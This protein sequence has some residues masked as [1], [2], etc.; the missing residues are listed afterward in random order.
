[1]A[2]L[3]RVPAALAMVFAATFLPISSRALDARHGIVLL[4]SSEPEG[5]VAT[6]SD[7]HKGR[8][9]CAAPYFL[10]S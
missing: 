9:P 6:L 1:M 4:M 7:K 5:K 2:G 8:S 3:L 10:S